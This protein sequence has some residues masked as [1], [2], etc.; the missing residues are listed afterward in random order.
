MNR[1]VN[2]YTNNLS[3]HSSKF[4]LEFHL[5]FYYSSRRIKNCDFLR[6]N[7]RIVKQSPFPYNDYISSFDII[8]QYTAGN[9][10][11]SFRY[12]VKFITYLLHNA[13]IHI[14]EITQDDKIIDSTN[15]QFI[16]NKLST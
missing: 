6:R 3:K 7:G 13:C 2:C 1:C 10:Y 9:I 12:L 16:A 4:S 11:F 14:Y 5:D 15:E 8:I